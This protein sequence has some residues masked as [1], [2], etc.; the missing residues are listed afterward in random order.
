MYAPPPPPP[1]PHLLLFAG[2]VEDDGRNGDGAC[3]YDDSWSRDF[4]S[5]RVQW[6]NV[7]IRVSVRVS[8]GVSISVRGP[9]ASVIGDRGGPGRSCGDRARCSDFRGGSYA[10]DDEL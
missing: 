1:S 6:A 4:E 2:K 5:D 7:G 10:K 9:P 8:V 3:R